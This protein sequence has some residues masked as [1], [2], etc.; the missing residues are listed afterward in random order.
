MRAWMRLQT[1][2][3][4]LL[5][6]TTHAR[7]QALTA[8]DYVCY[9]DRY[10]TGSSYADCDHV[11]GLTPNDF[12]CFARK[13]AAGDPYADCDKEEWINLSPPAGAIVRYV[14]ANGE[15]SACSQSQPCTLQEAMASTPTGTASQILFRCGD[16][17]IDPSIDVKASGS[18]SSYFVFG[19]WGVGPRPKLRSNGTIFHFGSGKV[20][21]ALDGLHLE[22][23]GTEQNK[24]SM[25]GQDGTRHV[26]VQD[27]YINKWGDGI[28]FHAVGSGRLTD[29]IINRNIVVDIRDTDGR[30]QGMF[31]GEVDGLVI[32]GNV[33]DFNGRSTGEQTIFMHN[34]YVHE[35]CGPVVFEDNVSTRGT[36]HGLQARP[37]GRVRGNLFAENGI[38]CY[39]GGAANVA[40]DLSY[41]VV[42]GGRDI[43][44]EH[45]RGIGFEIGGRG[46][47]E[48]NIAAHQK[49]GTANVTA[50]SF[51]GFNSGAVRRNTVHKWTAP[52]GQC[53]ATAAEWNK[54]SG[55]ITVE[56]NRFEM[57]GPGMMSRHE[58]RAYSSQFTYIANH[59][60]TTT[61]FGQGC[62]GYAQFSTSSG[63]GVDWNSWQTPTRDA[64]GTFG[65][66][67]SLDFTFEAYMVSIGRSGGLAEFAAQCRLQSRSNWRYEFTPAA[68]LAFCEAQL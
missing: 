3:S 5:L 41:N 4:V 26:L 16:E 61:P 58:S 34:V 66:M 35:T 13:Y 21:V 25:F 51:S 56:D 40:N 27:C 23:T 42:I 28:V 48:G 53:W 63:V 9:L 17:W 60:Y 50:M 38:N 36:S 31:F 52:G 32:R 15:G 33:L 10:V 54:G 65:P 37:G 1:L 55:P 18:T 67:P 29:I 14:S 47:V 45:P 62:N 57:T 22:Y 44:A 24:S 7:G 64:A 6:I 49:L 46:L 2:I 68:F 39:I 8:A 30:C 43:S 12:M 19:A 20:G 59:Y 11:G